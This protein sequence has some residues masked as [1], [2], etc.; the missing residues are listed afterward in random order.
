MSTNILEITEEEIE[1]LVRKGYVNMARQI[2][3]V[4]AARRTMQQKL[5]ERETTP[6]PLPP[7]PRPNLISLN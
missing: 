5:K 6:L 1:L 7:V 3:E 2:R 4:Q